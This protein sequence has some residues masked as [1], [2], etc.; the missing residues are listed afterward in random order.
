MKNDLYAIAD[1]LTGKDIKLI[2][3]KLCM[4]QVE[5]AG[6]VNVT[7]KTIERWEADKTVITGPIVTLVKILDDNPDILN[8]LRIPEKVYP[9]RLWYM[10]KREK[11]AVIDVDE[12]GRRVK[13][14][15]FT[16]DFIKRPFGRLENP[17]FEQYEDF[18]ESRCF[19]R[20]RDK[21]KLVLQDLD[22]PF[23]EPLM[24]IEKTQGKM[25]EDDFWIKIERCCRV[26]ELFNKDTNTDDRQ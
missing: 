24:I 14:H 5:F 20:S 21:M 10:F 25:A 6:L 13:L 1:G 9:M 11:C 4:T 7:K 23:Y 26:V 2:R 18:L 16:N 19:P 12:R 22:L 3:K 17:T 8:N 15:N